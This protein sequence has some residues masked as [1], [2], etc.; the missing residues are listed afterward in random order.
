MEQGGRGA[1]GM[2]DN[3]EMLR[4]GRWM[5]S[6]RARARVQPMGGRYVPESGRWALG[7]C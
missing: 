2:D 4:P 5:G 6:E 3:G 1:M 7:N